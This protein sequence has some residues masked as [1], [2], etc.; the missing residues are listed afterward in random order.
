[1]ARGFTNHPLLDLFRKYF[2]LVRK[3]S[4]PKGVLR[5]DT[6]AK[7]SSVWDYMVTQPS[8]PLDV[9]LPHLWTFTTHLDVVTDQ[10]EATTFKWKET[11]SGS[12]TPLAMQDEH[13]GVARSLNGAGDNN[14]YF[15]ESAV[16]LVLPTSGK[17]IWFECEVKVSD[18]DQS[19]F[20]FGLCARLAA[21]NLFDNRVN[22]IGFRSDDGDA[23]IDTV[24][25]AASSTTANTSQGTLVDDT[26]IKMGFRYDGT[27]VYF[28]VGDT[29]TYKALHAANIPA[30]ELCVAFGLR[31]GEAVAKSISVRRIVLCIEP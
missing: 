28:F 26:W 19:D 24:T 22:A 2:H 7:N 4:D 12:G 17:Q 27:A 1:M 13:G 10:V 29:D 9:I 20:F 11:S 8:L 18:A 21:G 30:T 6:G 31:N 3:S 15:Y 16:E 23:Y 5:I 14:F 25:T